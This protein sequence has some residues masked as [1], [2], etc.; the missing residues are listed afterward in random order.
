MQACEQVRDSVGSSREKATVR[1]REREREIPH[2]ARWGSAPSNYALSRFDMSVDPAVWWNIEAAEK[3]VTREAVDAVNSGDAVG[4]VG[5]GDA[6]GAVDACETLVAIDV[7]ASW[8]GT[9]R[10]RVALTPLMCLGIFVRKVTYWHLH[11]RG[12]R[13]HIF[14]ASPQ[15]SRTPSGLFGHP[16]RLSMANSSSA[17][18]TFKH[19]R[20]LPS[21]VVQDLIN[22]LNVIQKT[23]PLIL[24]HDLSGVSGNEWLWLEQDRSLKSRVDK[25]GNGK[26]YISQHHSISSST[27]VLHK[28][29]TLLPQPQL[30][31]QL[32]QTCCRQSPDRS[33]CPPLWL[34]SAG[35]PKA[36]PLVLTGKRTSPFRVNVI[37]GRMSSRRP[38][39]PLRMC[40][41]FG[42]IGLVLENLRGP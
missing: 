18:K 5:A 24:L 29:T 34:E 1:E 20:V 3:P 25:I 30:R 27:V 14:E 31:P 35:M 13:L 6:V 33:G 8:L 38:G 2:P 10:L 4:A 23:V 12:S 37:K 36:G 26:L 40:Q 19:R 32:G 39:V 22:P 41:F 9:S 21:S 17:Y 42:E 11:V 15:K 16:V 7:F 28:C